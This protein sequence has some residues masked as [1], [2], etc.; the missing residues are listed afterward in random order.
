VRGQSIAPGDLHLDEVVY[1]PAYAQEHFL[2]FVTPDDQVAGYLRLSLPEE[3]L[4]KVV[5][6]D[7][8]SGSKPIQGF[9]DLDGAAII[10]EVHVYGQSLQVGA[11]KA[12]AAQH[13]GLGTRLIAA[14][15]QIARQH[16]F[17]RLAVISAVGTRQ[18]YRERGFE[19]GELYM[20][21]SLEG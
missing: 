4:V 10:R 8:G 20:I 19:I 9:C 3:F 2:S 14:A 7:E 17:K 12:G 11:E 15:E 16:G 5:S 18:Y 21:K 13:S 6:A 1:H